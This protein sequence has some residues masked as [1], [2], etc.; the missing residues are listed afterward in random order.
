MLETA[1]GRET[2]VERGPHIVVPLERLDPPALRALAYA[3]SI[4]GHRSLLVRDRRTAGEL[5]RAGFDTTAEIV[6]G[7]ADLDPVERV[8]RFLEQTD[9]DRPV[10]VVIPEVV[11]KRPWLYPL[12]DQT[13]LRLKLRLFFRPNTVVI[14]VP[15]H[16]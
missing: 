2:V 12:H 1:L 6:I 16:V 10:A 14:D 8:L 7:P 13:G 5:R 9:G 15:Y 3:R 11:P 4:A